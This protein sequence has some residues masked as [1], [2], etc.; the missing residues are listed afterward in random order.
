MYPISSWYSHL[1]LYTFPTLFIPL[2]KDEMDALIRGE[3]HQEMIDK[4]QRGIN[5]LPGA[6]FVYADVCAPIDSERFQK[7]KG[8][9]RSG[10][11]A[12]NMLCESQCVKTAFI[13]KQTRRIT[14]AFLPSHDP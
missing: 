6:S 7:S 4:L 11:A 3:T 1:S 10:L 13:K 9:A 12:W 14:M 2:A 5:N 8:A